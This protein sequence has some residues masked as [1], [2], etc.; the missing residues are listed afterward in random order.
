MEMWG[1]TYPVSP[2]EFNLYV[3]DI[4]RRT[5]ENNEHGIKV[6][7]KSTTFATLM[8]RLF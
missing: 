7:D 5:L 4:M 6:G 1:A 2:M 8:T 3:E